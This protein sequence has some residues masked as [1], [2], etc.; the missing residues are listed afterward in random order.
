MERATRVSSPWELSTDKASTTTR[1]EALCEEPSLIAS[2]KVKA[3]FS[4]QMETNTQVI[5]RTTRNLVKVR[6]NGSQ[7]KSMK[8]ITVTMPC[9]AKAI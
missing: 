1:G 8:E 2:S 5:S 7:V 6:S 4:R 3:R 9:T